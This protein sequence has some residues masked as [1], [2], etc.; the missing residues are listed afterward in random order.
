MKMSPWSATEAGIFSMWIVA[1]TTA[2]SSLYIS[3][4]YLVYL[5]LL[6]FT[7]PFN[8]YCIVAA[9]WLLSYQA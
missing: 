9:M 6:I 3:V 8:L 1:G 5:L 4:T 7:Y 2:T